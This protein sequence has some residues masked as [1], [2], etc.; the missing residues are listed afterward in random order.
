MRWEAERE[1]A[2]PETVP[3]RCPVCG[4]PWPDYQVWDGS[5]RALGC[6]FCLT[7]QRKGVIQ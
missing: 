5:R 4:Y 6:E 2:P 7:I 3:M 1:T